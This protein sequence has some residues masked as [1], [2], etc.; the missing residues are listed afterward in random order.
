M[1]QN[2]IGDIDP[3]L[4]NWLVDAEWNRSWSIIPGLTTDTTKL[5][6]QMQRIDAELWTRMK[7]LTESTL[8]GG[9]TWIGKS[10]VR[11]ILERRQKLQQQIDKLVRAGSEAQVFIR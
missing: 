6:H 11:A 5:I 7:M 4:G 9:R 10:E 2:L 8:T 1:F 3:N